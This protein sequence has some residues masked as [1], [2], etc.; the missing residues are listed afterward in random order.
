M[1]IQK[2]SLFI[3]WLLTYLFLSLVSIIFIYGIHNIYMRNIKNDLSNLNELYLSQMIGIFDDQFKAIDQ[4]SY[5]IGFDKDLLRL[6]SYEDELTHNERYEVAEM[7]NKLDLFSQS[8]NLVEKISIY[9]FKPNMVWGESAVFYEEYIDLYT[10]FIYGV[11]ASIF[12]E[13]MSQWYK[14]EVIRMDDWYPINDVDN[15]L[16]YLQ[17]LPIQFHNNPKGTL[18]F[19]INED[20]L[21]ELSAREFFPN[22]KIIIANDRNQI[23]FSNDELLVMG[24]LPIEKLVDPSD[25]GFSYDD[26]DYIKGIKSSDFNN[27]KYISLIPEEAYFRRANEVERFIAILSVIFLAVNFYIAYFF[28]KKMYQPVKKI[29]GSLGSQT[30]EKDQSEYDYIE[31]VVRTNTQEIM[32]ME[33]DI[34]VK[35]Q[36]LKNVFLS[37]LVRGSINNPDNIRRLMIE[38]DISISEQYQIVLIE[39]LGRDQDN[40]ISL[41]Q[42]IIHNV[43]MEVLSNYY[44]C[45]VVE[46]ETRVAIII[47]LDPESE[48]ITALEPDMIGALQILESKFDLNC[49]IGIGEV[50]SGLSDIQTAYLESVEAVMHSHIFKD[51]RVIFQGDLGE[52]NNQ[53]TYS[54]D[55][56]HKI[57]LQIN[58][59][60]YEE[61]NKLIGEVIHRN[62]KDNKVKFASI[63]CLMF[64]I[65]GTMIKS[66][67]DPVFSD[68][69]EERDVVIQ[70]MRASSIEEMKMI[71]M[72][73]ARFACD[74]FDLEQNKVV[75]AGIS[76]EVEAYVRDHYS[77]VELN[78]SHLGDVFNITPTYLSR[79]YKKETGTSLLQFINT[80]RIESSKELL[81][82]THLSVNE[83]ANEVGYLYSNAFIR[84]FKKQTGVTPGQYKTLYSGEHEL[85]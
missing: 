28:S 1:K 22:S 52:L 44:S 18:I 13:L 77:E 63:Q 71:I 62:V 16:F 37:K 55:E 34:Y 50:H 12:D 68:F 70:L 7:M 60:N 36:S 79:L 67:D 69:L 20:K 24:E 10:K 80:I 75:K 6:L 45:N 57:V 43:F 84:F 26:N 3:K 47:N 83:I 40:N 78:V 73:I 4:L 66:V 19:K 23:I 48:N 54:L 51:K 11:N 61:T 82:K 25:D 35:K 32:A 29:M 2:N 42:F 76:Q 5:T 46:V 9:K 64:D 27:W 53:Y 17:T 49:S 39:I 56:E 72:E 85:F 59:G 81:I 33:R 8:N 38:H 15:P 14:E 41:S 21:K 74:I 31:K 65:L 58:L 30:R